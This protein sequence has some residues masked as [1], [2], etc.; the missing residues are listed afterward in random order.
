MTR[1]FG[2]VPVSCVHTFGYPCVVMCVQ[3]RHQPLHRLRPR[4]YLRYWHLGKAKRQKQLGESAVAY[5][6]RHDKASSCRT[7]AHRLVVLA[8]YWFRCMLAT[9]ISSCTWG[10]VLPGYRTGPPSLSSDLD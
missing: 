3:Q 5:H 4:S 6:R 7:L 2:D 1:R 8:C 9:P 10:H